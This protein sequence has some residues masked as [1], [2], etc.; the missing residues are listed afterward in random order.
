M[1]N[2]FLKSLFTCF[3]VVTTAGQAV[4]AGI[5]ETSVS[6]EAY[7]FD[8]GYA[9]TG[10]LDDYGNKYSSSTATP[11]ISSGDLD[12]LGVASSVASVSTTSITISTSESANP[13]NLYDYNTTYGTGEVSFTVSEDTSFT[14][15]DTTSGTGAGYN[16]M[17]LVSDTTGQIAYANN[18]NDTQ[19]ISGTLYAGQQYHLSKQSYN[20]YYYGNAGSSSGIVTLSTTPVPEPSSFA[21]L[22]LGCLG[23]AFGA[24]RRRLAVV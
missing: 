4:H 24:Y 16:L 20:G 21:L 15:T 3:A 13:N 1:R 9:N 23:L 6:T 7:A 18:Q 8:Y 12:Q 5:I 11:V 10:L 19:T 14:L 17:S 22:C 2:C